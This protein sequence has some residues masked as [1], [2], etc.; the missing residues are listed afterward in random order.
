M[1]KLVPLHLGEEN[2]MEHQE[3]KQNE[4]RTTQNAGANQGAEGPSLRHKVTTG[5]FWTYAERILAQI[6]TTVV[7]LVLARLLSPDDYGAISLVMVFISICEVFVTSGF[8]NAL[9]QKRDADAL[10]FSSIFYFSM[11]LAALLY[12]VLFAAAPFV[13]GFYRSEILC[14]VLRVLGV[15]LLLSSFNSIQRA[16]ISKR[17]AFRKFFRA[18]VIGTVISAFVGIGLALFGFGVWALVG[19]YLTNSLF[20]T[21][22]LFFSID[23]RPK[24]MLS[25][26]R[27]KGLVSYGWKLLA[28]SLIET[29][30]YNLRS[31]VIG[32]LFSEAD[33]AFYDKGRHFPEII[34]LNANSPITA[35]IFPAIANV[36]DDRERVRMLTRRSIRVSIY[37][38]CPLLMGMAAIAEPLV[39]VL[40]T[41]KWLPCV[42]YLQ[43]ACFNCL[44]IPINTANLQPV[45]ALGRSDLYLKLEII[46]KVVGI[47]ILLGTVV[48]FR[49]VIAIAV[50]TMV[51]SVLELIINS[52][53]NKKLFGYSLLEELRDILPT[54]LLGMGMS[55]VVLLIGRLEL[56]AAA[57]LALQIAAG[58]AMYLGVSYLVRMESFVYILDIIKGLLAK[59]RAEKN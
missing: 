15:R 53:Q 6:V 1:R 52:S 14:P 27:L 35:V 23:W 44:I 22:I 36:Q 34:A 13:A 12:G 55:A 28:S 32:K 40:L 49:S 33:L 9:V 56:P 45:M 29:V 41:D 30:Y 50:G 43:I 47:S 39:Q 4:L 59:K 54:L 19:Q 31:L 58:A 20:D 18:T 42:P 5:L 7:S 46:K 11:F 37:I 2:A 48:C 3:P 8:G 10:D 26:E 21:V 16:Y 57:L 24:R 17:M 38:M 25:L 51:N